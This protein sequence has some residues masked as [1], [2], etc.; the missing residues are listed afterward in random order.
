MSW[1]EE[2]S[3]AEF[4]RRP[5]GAFLRRRGYLL[6]GAA[7]DLLVLMT[8]GT[9]ARADMDELLT[10]AR[11]ACRTGRRPHDLLVEA[12]RLRA[13]DDAAFAAL[14]H[15]S[16][17]SSVPIRRCALI[18]PEG[19]LGGLLVELGRSLVR[20]A[21]LFV[22]ARTEAA[23]S[24]LGIDDPQCMVR[25]RALAVSIAESG[26][27]LLS[28]R[29]LIS[30][31]TVSTVESAAAE[32][33]LS[34]R[35]LQRR[36]RSAGTRFERERALSWIGQAKVL[37]ERTDWPVKYIASHIGLSSPV[38]LVQIFRHYE[39][40]TPRKWRDATKSGRSDEPA[41]ATSRKIYE[42]SMA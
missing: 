21:P 5:A 10:V 24:W 20:T 23:F 38:R 39:Q 41:S 36:L 25:Y 11:R 1:R 26:E 32:L 3:V 34:V 4:L 6:L 8:W 27:W 22:T 14:L 18:V 33:G 17:Q 2:P 31:R 40:T 35:T 15:F 37:L 7:D 19:D 12:T 16:R 42:D 29:Q 30:A 13:V 28:L 9:L